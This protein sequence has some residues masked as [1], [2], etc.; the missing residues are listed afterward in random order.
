MDEI[1]NQINYVMSYYPEVVWYEVQGGNSVLF[2]ICQ[3]PAS[4]ATRDLLDKIRNDL[5]KPLKE[6]FKRE[7]IFL[8]F[9][10]GLLPRYLP[11]YIN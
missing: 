5:E 1:V 10:D 9:T 11:K 2:I 6:R 3:I 8:Y 7:F 4:K